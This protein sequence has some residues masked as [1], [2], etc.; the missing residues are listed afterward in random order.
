MRTIISI[1]AI[2]ILGLVSCQK[3][4]ILPEEPVTP[5]ATLNQTIILDASKEELST[6]SETNAELHMLW[7]KGD[8]IAVHVMRNNTGRFLKFDLY[9]GDGSTNGKFRGEIAGDESLTPFA[10]YPYQEDLSI[11]GTDLS[12]ELPQKRNYTQSLDAPMI[13]HIN[14]D[15]SILEFKHLCGFLQ[16]TLENVPT[17]ATTFKLIASKNIAG[18]CMINFQN[19]ELGLQMMD[20]ASNS[21]VVDLTSDNPSSTYQILIPVPVGEYASMSF[22][23]TDATG[24]ELTNI[25]TSEIS[26]VK[27][28]SILNIPPIS[29]E[30][31]KPE[32]EVTHYRIINGVT[33]QN[34]GLEISKLVSI[35][36]V[37]VSNEY[38]TIENLNVSDGTIYDIEGTTNRYVRSIILDAPQKGNSY[39]LSESFDVYL[40]PIK[41]NFEKIEKIYP[42][43]ENSEAYKRFLGKR[44]EYVDPDNLDIISIGDEIWDSSTDILDYARRCYEYVASHYKYL[45]A[46]TGIHP[47]KKILQD[48]GGDCGNLTSIY[49]SLLRYKNIP[50]KHIVT[51]RPDGS[52]H[53]WNDFYLEKHGWI[54]VDVTAKNSDPN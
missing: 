5:P 35:L 47:L 54:P 50:S 33:F 20:N 21:I 27:R 31:S 45:N 28:A 29:C 34:T 3:E 26:V 52:Y 44:G 53:V 22:V 51:V 12:F 41:I 19:E 48:G 14:E 16:F 8:A 2:I 9:Q 43:D 4:D 30:I 37:P 40:R 42:Y 10:I 17:N 24:N 38:Q 6:I 1:L 23:L 15:K 25:S 7:K 32:E 36:P 49:V 18:N 13:A 11:S 39:T 46:N